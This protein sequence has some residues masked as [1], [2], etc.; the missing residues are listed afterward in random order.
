MSQANVAF[1]A[2]R[3]AEPP[4]Q[5]PVFTLDLTPVLRRAL[6]GWDPL[7]RCREVAS[8]S[9]NRQGQLVDVLP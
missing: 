7:T 1:E 5:S 6:S 2:S 8:S 3:A 4:T 9:V